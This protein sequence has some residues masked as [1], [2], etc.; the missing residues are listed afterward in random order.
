MAKHYRIFTLGLVVGAVCAYVLAFRRAQKLGDAFSN[1]WNSNPSVMDFT[2]TYY[3]D[4]PDHHK[5]LGY[6]DPP[7][8]VYPWP[9]DRSGYQ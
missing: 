5:R 1:N 4:I 2:A 3:P 9:S 6:R 7:G 8:Y